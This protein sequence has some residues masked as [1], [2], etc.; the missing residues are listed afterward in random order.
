MRRRRRKISLS[1]GWRPSLRRELRLRRALCEESVA[2][3]LLWPAL[4]LG[5]AATPHC[6]AMCGAA[7]A[8][9]CSAG[10]GRAEPRAWTALLAGRFLGYAA[11]GAIVGGAFEGL[12]WL[13]GSGPALRPLWALFHAGVLVYGLYVLASAR[14]PA[15]AIRFSD[16]FGRA[17]RRRGAV[18][19]AGA[20]LALMP[21]AML[22]SALLIAS[23]SGDSVAGALCM[24]VFAAGSSLGL[25]FGPAV[26]R[27]FGQAMTSRFGVAASRRERVATRLV[28]LALAVSGG[29]ALW[30]GMKAQ[31]LAWCA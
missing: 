26:G 8:R 14:Q 9:V 4:L 21:C 20:L 31:V 2:V 7:C 3:T 18:V 12:Y 24:A 5:L 23:L 27:C 15:W 6:A 29:W 13:T 25:V 11:A 10:K 17:L 1:L 16:S 28:G 22:Y 30:L 19:G